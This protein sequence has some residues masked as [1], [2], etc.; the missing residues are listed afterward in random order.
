MQ[1]E[2]LQQQQAQVQE[3]IPYYYVRE[4]PN[5]PPPPYTPPGQ[6]PR[7]LSSSTSLTSSVDE[8]RA[9]CTDRPVI[10]E[11][12][13]AAVNLLYDA[14]SQGLDLPSQEAPNSFIDTGFGLPQLSHLSEQVWQ[15]Y[16]NSLLIFYFNYI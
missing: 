1:I 12:I 5:K 9:V 10:L 15:F 16:L 14:H 8:L 4:I 11:A 7:V 2:Q 6:A 13:A 3:Q